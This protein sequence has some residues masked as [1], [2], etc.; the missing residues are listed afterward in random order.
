MCGR[1]KLT[2]K[3]IEE[4]KMI[5][6]NV[7]KN[8]YEHSEGEIYPSDKMALLKQEDD[9]VKAVSMVWGFEGFKKG[10][11]IINARSE[12]VNEKKMFAESFFYQ[13][14]VIPTTGYF[15]W[16]SGEQKFLCKKSG[17]PVLYLGGFVKMFDDGMRCI[18][19]TTA[20]NES[21][22]KVHSRMPIVLEREQIR[23]WLDD[24]DYANWLLRQPMMP[25]EL[26][27]VSA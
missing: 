11:L 7:E 23:M 12:T 13:R 21:V 24:Y 15:E 4:L 18:I 3:D 1:V 5:I 6:R 26:T 10:Q 14:C 2:V 17:D 22:S 25:L 20:A 19:L 9:H 27:K 16:D 8:G